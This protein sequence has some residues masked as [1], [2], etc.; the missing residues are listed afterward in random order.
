MENRLIIQSPF[1][2]N[3]KEDDELRLHQNL[4][5]EFNPLP[6]HLRFRPLYLFACIGVWFIL[7]LSALT[8]YSAVFAFVFGLLNQLS[9]GL[10][11]AVIVTLLL[12]VG[13]EL[14]HRFAG[15]TYFKEFWLDGGKHQSDNNGAL[16]GLLLCALVSLGMSIPGGFDLVSNIQKKP[17]RPRV[18][19]EKP[20]DVAAILNPYIEEAQNRVQEY[21]SSRSWRGKL[22]D[23]DA[24]EWKRRTEVAEQREQDLINA[25]INVPKANGDKQTMAEQKYQQDLARWRRETKG[26][27]S[28]FGVLSVLTTILM[29]VCIWFQ[30]KYKKKTQEYLDQKY[31]ELKATQSALPAPSIPLA[32]SPTP[33][34]NDLEPLLLSIVKRLDNLDRSS[35]HLLPN[36]PAHPGDSSP[37]E[38]P[39]RTRLPIGFKLPDRSASTDL[40]KV[41][42]QGVATSCNEEILQI[43]REAE[44]LLPA[45]PPLDDIYTVEHRRFTDG[46][47]IRH[48]KERI[49]WYVT[50]YH[51]QV[52]KAQ[53]KIQEDPLN[54]SLRDS[55]LNFQEKLA[56]WKSLEDQLLAKLKT[57]GIET[58]A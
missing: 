52:L 49:K 30:F 21:K 54:E 48:G 20:E 39:N 55:L 46:K 18:K 4:S 38:T 15:N 34:P 6:Y 24:T 12:I 19:E 26:N 28:V 1:R 3:E 56:Y 51:D 23:K 32:S 45:E 40:P 8:E 57:A 13:F 31:A 7:A 9:F 29:Y 27:G 58:G 5:R 25:I 14:L 50:K 44:D 43:E 53:Q 47:V 42:L 35:L 22:S 17:E 37:I 16:L 11:L 41:P 2:E 33:T 10:V 36:A